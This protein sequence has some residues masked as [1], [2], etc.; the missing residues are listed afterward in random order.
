MHNNVEVGVDMMA[1]NVQGL[2]SGGCSFRSVTLNP[3]FLFTRPVCR[4][5]GALAPANSL[6][7]MPVPESYRTAAFI[8]S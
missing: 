7:I 6:Q 1:K 5:D 3:E 4:L 8:V 2:G